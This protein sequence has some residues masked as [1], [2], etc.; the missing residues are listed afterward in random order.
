MLPRRYK[1]YRSPFFAHLFSGITAVAQP[2]SE[3]SAAAVKMLLELMGGRAPDQKVVIIAPR[4]VK[5]GSCA[6]PPE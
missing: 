6:P 3:M 4:L 1:E 5:R 2:I